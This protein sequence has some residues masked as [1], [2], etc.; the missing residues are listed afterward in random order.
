[1]LRGLVV[2]DG[3]FVDVEDRLAFAHHPV[4]TSADVLAILDRIVR[5]L[6]CRLANEVRDDSVDEGIDV[7]AQIQAEAA[8]T[9]CSPQNGKPT[10]RGVERLRAWCEGFSLHADVVVADHLREA[11]VRL[12]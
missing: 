6:A 12:C 7:L 3:V 2:P 10:A 1:M 9:W 4:P 11:L 8:A 5:L